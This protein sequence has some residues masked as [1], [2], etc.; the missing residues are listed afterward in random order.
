MRWILHLVAIASAAGTFV[1]L[2]SAIRAGMMSPFIGVFWIAASVVAAYCL[3]IVGLGLFSGTP[4]AQWLT[5][6]RQLFR[7]RSET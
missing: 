2:E 1:A 6:A 4:P 7:G 3:L 5:M